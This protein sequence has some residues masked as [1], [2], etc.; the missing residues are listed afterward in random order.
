MKNR[1]I[2]ISIIVVAVIV[3]GIMYMVFFKS[4]TVT[5]DSQG[6]RWYQSQQVRKNDVAKNPGEA[7]LTGYEFLGWYLGDEEY[8]F[9]TPVTKDITLTAKF[10]KVD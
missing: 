3:L 7:T 8:N 1:I 5:F 9:S 4:Y 10:K 2:P 6:G